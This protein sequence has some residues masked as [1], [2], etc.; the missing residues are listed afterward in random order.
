MSEVQKL[1]QRVNAVRP[2]VADLALRGRVD[3]ERFMAGEEYEVTAARAPVMRG[4]ATDALMLTEALRGEIVAVFDQTAD[5]WAWVQLA[6]DRY[7]GWTPLEHLSH[8]AS[9]STHK[10][11]AFTTLLFA[12]PDIKTPVLQN[13][14][15]GAKLRVV[16]EEQDR[17]ASYAMISG[18]GAVVTQH[19]APLD[20][21]ERDWVAVAE[22]FM[23]IP[24]LWG[25]K[26]SL[27][28]D[29]SGLIQVALG[30]CG[31]VAPRD[32]DMQQATL[33]TPLSPG[34]G[35]P[36]LKRG[37]LVFWRGHAGFMADAETLLHANAHHMAV[38][39]EPLRGAIARLEQK[40][41]PVATIRRIEAD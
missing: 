11:S 12:G 29:C 28:I 4:P 39:T 8:S 27:G 17:N 14:P 2:E 40:G 26:T 33:G 37:D 16:G 15:L 7:V 24:Y 1:D 25:G 18:G 36:P 30:A 3:A 35:L 9:E 10:V 20:A 22:R 13:L 5:G 6:A 38:A 41:L 32:T 34:A 31:I 19:I 23:G 21:V